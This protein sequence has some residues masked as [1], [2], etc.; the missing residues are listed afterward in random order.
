MANT[1]LTNQRQVLVEQYVH[2]GDR[3]E[4]AKKGG[5]KKIRIHFGIRLVSF[6]Q[7]E[8]A[9]EITEELH[10]NFVEIAPLRH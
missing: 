6:S 4:A 10:R 3:L 2:S 5:Y 9:D 7:K 1:N 8:C